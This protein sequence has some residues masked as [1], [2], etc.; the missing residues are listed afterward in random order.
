MGNRDYSDRSDRV[1]VSP[2]RTRFREIEYAVPLEDFKEV[3]RE[4]MIAVNGFGAGI[5]F[6]LEVRTA[7][8]DDTWLGTAS[9]RESAYIALHRFIKEDH[10]PYFA[11]VE[12]ILRAAG[13]RPHWGKIHTLTAP[14]LAQVYPHFEDFLRVRRDVDPGGMFANAYLDRVLGL[15]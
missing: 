11:A 5:T 12:P 6:P 15:R 1:F 9:G 4:V 10:V 13:G 3:F 7:G 8:A 14:D 2:R